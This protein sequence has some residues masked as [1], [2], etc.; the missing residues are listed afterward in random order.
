MLMKTIR[1]I[2]IVMFVAMSLLFGA[3]LFAAGQTEANVLNFALSGNPDTLDPHV[4][5]G[6]LT[7]QAIRSVYDTL[8]EPNL[9]GVLSPALAE[10]WEVSSD[11]LSWTFS[12]RK[13]VMFHNGDAFTS[14][15]VKATFERIT[16]PDIASPK[17]GEFEAIESILTPN[18][19][20][21]VFILSEPNAPLLSSM[22][23]GWGAIL[24]KTLIDSGHD[25]GSVPVGTGPFKL[26]EWLRDSKI[27]YEKN[28]SYWMTG[29]PKLDMVSMNI[30]VER[31]VQVQ[32]L[33]A[34]ELDAIY[35]VNAEDVAILRNA[36]GVNLERN[37]TSLVMVLAINTAREPLS[38]L[39]VR[40]AINHAIDKQTALDIAYGGGEVVGTFMDFND[41]YY[42]DTVGYYPYDPGKAVELLK[43]AG[44]GEETTL[45]MA[46]PQNFEP[47]VR[48]GEL[49]QEMLEK[50][51]LKV[52]L[53]LVD[54]STWLS[55][56]YRGGNY[57]L[58]VIGHT[59]KL[60]PAGRLGD[61]GTKATY[62]NWENATAADLIDRGRKTPDF[63][64]R[65]S[66]YSEALDIMAREVPHVY[67]GSSYRFIATRSNVSGFHMDQK[68]DTFDF[69]YTEKE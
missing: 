10:S 26:V 8:V 19:H 55:D 31:A 33:L 45:E 36:N 18:D 9:D 12:L 28:L 57:D 42:I 56:V 24:P 44:I 34:G 35:N 51:G 60:D 15:D 1:E 63:D 21:V 4:T 47:H 43:A 58:T 40:Q 67:V 38:N 13:G 16:D 20:T 11:G 48:A 25:F 23:S 65:K 2:A 27:V 66:L 52:K 46:L 37:L 3:T 32:A 49:Y 59:G 29:Y 6:T 62:V 61:Y 68:L 69:R 54:W 7:F 41:P 30:I 14:A 53:R 17:A 64:T 22:A 50:V 39:S 5:S